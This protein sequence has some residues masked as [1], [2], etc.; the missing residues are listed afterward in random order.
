M[1]KWVRVAVLAAYKLAFDFH[2]EGAENIPQDK[3]LIIASNH[4]SF[5]D[6]VII[7]IPM[8]QPLSYMARDTLFHNKLISWFITKLGAFP[9]KRDTAPAALFE[10]TTELLKKRSLVIFPEGTRQYE[11]KVGAGKSGVAMIAAKSG[12]DVLPCGIVFEGKKLRFRSKLTLRFGEVI[13]YDELKIEGTSSK[14]LKKVKNLIMNAIKRLVE[15]AVT[16]EMPQTAK[17]AEP[18]A[19]TKKG[20][21]AVNEKAHSD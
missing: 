5:A 18:E 1:Y 17:S 6:P 21:E 19:A 9:I 14:E 11:N 4:R 10:Q 13:K 8:K 3:P 15:G 16:V 20:G 7:T 12:A 2:I